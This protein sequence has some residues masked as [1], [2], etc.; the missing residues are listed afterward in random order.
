MKGSQVLIN[1]RPFD[2]QNG[3]SD[4]FLFILWHNHCFAQMSL[5]IVQ[6]CFSGEQ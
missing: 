2:S 3:D 6:N 4:V 1:N 5:L